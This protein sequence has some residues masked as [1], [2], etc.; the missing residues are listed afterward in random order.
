[1]ITTTEEY[2]IRAE[3]IKNVIIDLLFIEKRKL[4]ITEVTIK[5]KVSCYNVNILRVVK[6]INDSKVYPP[7]SYYSNSYGVLTLVV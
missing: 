5:Q 4:A 2:N 1:M 6:D 3:K 7:I